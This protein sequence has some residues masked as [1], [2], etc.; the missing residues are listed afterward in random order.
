M[1]WYFILLIAVAAVAVLVTF[2]VFSTAL[3]IHHTVFGCRQDKNPLFK[4][5]TADDFGISKQSFPVKLGKNEISCAIYG[6]QLLESSEKVVIFAH[7]FGAGS[8]SYTTEIA[9]FVK[10]GFPVVAYDAYGCNESAGKSV[11][12]FYA[13]TYSLIATFNAVKA[14]ARFNGKKIVVVGHSWGAYSALAASERIKVDGVVTMSSFNKP[15][16]AISD[17]LKKMGGV[18][19]AYS[20][21]VH[22]AF[23]F[24]N[25][26]KFGARGNRSA[27]RAIVKSGVPALLIHGADDRLAVLPHSAAAKAEGKNVTKLIL[28]GKRH[29][30]YNTPAAEIKLSALN[31]AV[32]QGTDDI[33]FFKNFDWKGATE[34][35]EEVMAKIDEFIARV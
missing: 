8:A 27:S 2:I 13:G 1:E 5:F 33:D 16:Q 32:S 34:T 31:K 3:V 10:A 6:G 12:G 26:C 35:D 22:P 20:G 14:D 24:I 19:K 30:P 4:Y 28:S 23:W 21:L 11:K 9:H 7:G 25:L 15:A 18:A 17:S 29:N